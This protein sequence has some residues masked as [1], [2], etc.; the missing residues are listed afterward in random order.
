MKRLT[1][2]ASAAAIEA[3][4]SNGLACSPS[5]DPSAVEGEAY[6]VEPDG[7]LKDRDRAVRHGRRR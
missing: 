4:S 1:S 6:P 5:A 2:S 3:P 7:E